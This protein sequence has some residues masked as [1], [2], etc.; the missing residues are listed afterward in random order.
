MDPAPQPRVVVLAGPNGA[1]KTT[2]AEF[3]LHDALAVEEFVN[4][5]LIAKG[6]SV[7]DPEAAGIAAG[8]LMLA[9]LRELAAHHRSFAFETTLA[10]RTFAPWIADLR[11]E[12]NFTFHVVFLWLP[13]SEFALDRVRQRVRSGGHDVPEATVRRRYQRGLVNF[14]NLYRPMADTWL[15]YD[16]SRASPRLV[17][18]G[19]R[20][21]G[22]QVLDRET[23][24]RILE[25][26]H[27][28]RK[29][30]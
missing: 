21:V 27:D 16:S 18:H 4:A 29:A 1:G 19:G 25:T 22:E 5:D 20:A 6:L 7:F 13:T 23:W 28:E 9:R 15:C 8:R 12:Q 2:A 17:A 10:S 26:D 24:A 14:L 11:R 3:I 30:T